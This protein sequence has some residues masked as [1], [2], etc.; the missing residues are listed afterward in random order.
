MRA[1]VVRNFGGPEVLKVEENVPVPKP[2]SNQ[3]K[4]FTESII[5]SFLLI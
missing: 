2:D 4:F 1:I 3:V 5:F